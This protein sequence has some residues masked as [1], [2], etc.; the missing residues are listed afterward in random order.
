VA[1]VVG[2]FDKSLASALALACLLLAGRSV[3]APAPRVALVV[4]NADYSEFPALPACADSATAVA[5]ALRRL[6]FEVIERNDVTSG[7]LGA[8]LTA[9]G[10]RMD[11]VGDAA[12]FLYVCGYGA[13]VNA[14]PFLLPVSANIRRENDILTQGVL[15]KTTL[16]LLSRS[17]PR[18]G[19]L[20]LDL[21]PLPDSEAPPLESLAE[22]QIPSGVGV[23]A[24]IGA[25]PASG[26]TV[27]GKALA[28]GLS[29][30]EVETAALLSSVQGQVDVERSA[31]IAAL[32]LPEVSGPLALVAE[33]P[34]AP[35]VARPEPETPPQ[36]DAKPPPPKPLPRLPDGPDMNDGERR[37]VQ[38]ALKRVGYYAG[39]VDGIF[40]PETR[41]GIRRYQF[42]IGAE[43][44]GSIT[45]EQAVQLVTMPTSTNR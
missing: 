4:A 37:L 1:V 36:T 39:P 33:P 13:A 18:R 45:G 3:A 9:F 17:E 30:P 11:E 15:V 43:M 29:D 21:A 7:G 10:Q 44:T 22:L 24:A 35:P 14:R 27:L 32:Y 41:A 34:P 38:E 8:A 28:V 23:V 2:V 6:D 40:G 25:P 16:D 5:D 42:E 26:P 19:L 31:R 12:A 20:A